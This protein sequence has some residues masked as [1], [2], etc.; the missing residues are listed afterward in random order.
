MIEQAVTKLKELDLDDAIDRRFACA[1]D[2]S[3]NDVL[4]VDNSIRGRTKDALTDLLLESA[5]APALPTSDTQKITIDSLL[6]LAPSKINLILEN[7]HLSNFMSLS[8]PVHQD[9]QSLFKWD[10]SF[11]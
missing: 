8:A 9:V 5:K 3:V 1:E 11:G 10:N 6:R 4:F 2:I 7:R